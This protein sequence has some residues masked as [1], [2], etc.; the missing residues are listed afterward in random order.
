MVTRKTPKDNDKQS[1]KPKRRKDGCAITELPQAVCFP[2]QGENPIFKQATTT[3]QNPTYG[4][5]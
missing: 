5:K 2:L 4:G 1:N 3:F